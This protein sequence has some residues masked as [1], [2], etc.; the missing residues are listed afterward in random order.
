M[1][2]MI[3]IK[4][5]HPVFKN[6][7][8]S[9][10]LAAENSVQ[11]EQFQRYTISRDP[12]NLRNHVQLI[13]GLVQRSPCQREPLFAALADLF[14][15]LGSKGFA[16]RQRMLN[17]AKP[18]L[19]KEDVLFFQKHLKSDLTARIPLPIGINSI[20]TEAYIGK[21]NHIRKLEHISQQHKLSEYEQALELIDA[22][23]L[24]AAITLLQNALYQEPNNEQIAED[25]LNVA[26]HAGQ[27]H[28]LSEMQSW[29]IENNLEL[30][31]SWPLF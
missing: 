12:N 3:T 24:N 5:P 14:I 8:P 23:E 21:D 30:P 9:L 18:Y 22:G 2:N 29:F 19:E 17:T 10:L 13:L 28:I 20:L 15:V 16:L 7:Q 27:E 11:L 26:R 31:N 1:K 25:L 6:K 4:E